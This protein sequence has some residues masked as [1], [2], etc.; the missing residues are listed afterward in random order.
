MG[1]LVFRYCQ[2][3]SPRLAWLSSPQFAILSYNA[4]SIFF[5]CNPLHTSFY[6]MLHFNLTE[7][8]ISLCF[9]LSQVTMTYDHFRFKV[10]SKTLSELGIE[11][12]KGE[13][14]LVCRSV[15]C[16]SVCL[17]LPSFLSPS[18]SVSPFLS[19]LLPSPT[20]LYSFP[21]FPS[22]LELLM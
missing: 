10:A 3:P 9:T 6:R 19:R 15:V 20:F 16:L 2:R 14:S 11:I 18:H 4:P 17:S 12:L 1:P 22:W 21:F 7:D 13:V 5:F 8:K